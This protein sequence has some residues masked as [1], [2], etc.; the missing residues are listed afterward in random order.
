M[1][2]SRH[3]SDRRRAPRRATHIDAVAKTAHGQRHELRISDLSVSGCAISI[4]RGHP[5]TEGS[6]YGLKID[7]LETLGSTAAWAAG[8]SAGLEFLQPLHPAVAE[9]LTARH[10]APVPKFDPSDAPP[11]GLRRPD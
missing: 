8:Q 7:G 10:P 9:H 6:S 5:L 11:R 3:P 1:P 4:E 2:K